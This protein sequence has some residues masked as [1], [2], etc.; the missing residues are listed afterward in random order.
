M[1]GVS[2][3]S[4]L[5]SFQV[6]YVADEPV[7]LGFFCLSSVSVDPLHYSVLLLDTII[8]QALSQYIFLK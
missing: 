7:P 2:E 8:Q 1:E 3:Q 6:L 5:R 4:M